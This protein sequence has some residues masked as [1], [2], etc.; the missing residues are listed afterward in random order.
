MTDQPINDSID[1]EDLSLVD[2]NT[3]TSTTDEATELKV[4]IYNLFVSL[5]HHYVPTYGLEGAVQIS[6]D[7]LEEI[8][9]NFRST[10]DSE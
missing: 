1:P 4:G 6:T 5:F 10:L 2:D 3:T 7:F 9:M 8:I